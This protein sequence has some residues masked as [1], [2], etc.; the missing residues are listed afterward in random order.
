MPASVQGLRPPPQAYQGVAPANGVPEGLGEG[1]RPGAVVPLGGRIA[2]AR[3]PWRTRIPNPRLEHPRYPPDSK[4][5]PQKAGQPEAPAWARIT[6]CG[7]GV[8]RV[9][10][11]SIMSAR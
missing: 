7:T 2:L 11:I 10:E 5:A 4:G 1:V 3:M 6:C 8:R 9:S